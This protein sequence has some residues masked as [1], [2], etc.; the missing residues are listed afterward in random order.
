MTAR[1]ARIGA[2][3]RESAVKARALTRRG[4]HLL[5]GQVDASPDARAEAACRVERF[6]AD[7][8]AKKLAHNSK[9]DNLS[10]ERERWHS[11]WALG[12]LSFACRRSVPEGIRGQDEPLA[13]TCELL[14]LAEFLISVWRDKR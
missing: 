6:A 10:L 11:V 5:L 9:I 1:S 14:G 2:L 8:A 3:D 7:C 13:E 12:L 4:T